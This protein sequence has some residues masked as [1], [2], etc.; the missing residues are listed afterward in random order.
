[1]I[2]MNL[3]RLRCAAGLSRKEVAEYLN[4]SERA[5]SHYENGER[6]IR[7]DFVV[8]LADLYECSI[9]DVVLAQL[10]SGKSESPIT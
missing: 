5:I 8:K 6:H 7:L 2:P 10:R 1:M 9:G 3:K 4:V